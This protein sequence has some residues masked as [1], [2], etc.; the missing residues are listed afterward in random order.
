MAVTKRPPR[1][2]ALHG[3]A[4]L[5]ILKQI[6]LLQLAYYIVALVLILFTTLVAGK[7]FSLGLILSWKSLRGDTAVGW[8]L[9]L[10]WMLDSA[11]GYVPSTF[12]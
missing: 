4:P 6:C 12:T 2:G 3:H 11:I 8:T 9:G 10:C 7:P 5:R 1:A